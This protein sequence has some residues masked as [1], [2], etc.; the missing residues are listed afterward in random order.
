MARPGPKQNKKRTISSPFRGEAGQKLYKVP[1]VNVLTESKKEAK[2]MYGNKSL[3]KSLREKN[4]K[5][6][7][8][9][10]MRMSYK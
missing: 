9:A 7:K 3:M 1:G 2:A 8:D 5:L 4:K 6:S 10:Y